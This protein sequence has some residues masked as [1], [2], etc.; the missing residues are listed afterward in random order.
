[1]KVRELTD[2]AAAQ[3]GERRVGAIHLSN[4]TAV[5]LRNSGWLWGVNLAILGDI[6]RK[7]GRTYEPRKISADRRGFRAG[8]GLFG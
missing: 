3:T 6:H 8:S 1:M 2:A 4:G 7:Q 5:G